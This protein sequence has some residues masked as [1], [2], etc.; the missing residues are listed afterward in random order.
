MLAMSPAVVGQAT[1]YFWMGIMLILVASVERA[2]CR[3]RAGAAG[4]TS[5]CLR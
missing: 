5:S 4:A 3:H 2:G 1:P